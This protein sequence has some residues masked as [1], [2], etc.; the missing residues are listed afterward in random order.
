MALGIVCWITLTHFADYIY[1]PSLWIRIFSLFFTILF[2]GITYA[3]VCVAFQVE[4]A[5][6]IVTVIRRKFM[7]QK[8]SRDYRG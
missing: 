1:N 2:A 3:L 8:L 5:N 4:A 7:N 6:D